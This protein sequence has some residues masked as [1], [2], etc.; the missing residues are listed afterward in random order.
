MSLGPHRLQRT[1]WHIRR[2]DSLLSPAKR[3]GGPP[4]DRSVIFGKLKAGAELLFSWFG[5]LGSGP[6]DSPV[7]TIAAV[8]PYQ[9]LFGETMPIPM[10]L[11]KGPILDL[12]KILA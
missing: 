5:G 9:H 7:W 6:F 12:A 4:T 8:R 1:K 2:H 3:H 10:T 11:I